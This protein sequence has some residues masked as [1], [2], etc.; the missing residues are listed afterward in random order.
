MKDDIQK[1]SEEEEI[2][3]NSFDKEITQEKKIKDSFYKQAM[4][5]MRKVTQ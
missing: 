4:T 5:Y 2:T 1:N 3:Q